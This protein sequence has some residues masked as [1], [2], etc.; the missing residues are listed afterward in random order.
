MTATRFTPW[1]WAAAALLAVELAAAGLALAPAPSAAYR[2]Q[3]LDKTDCWHSGQ[4]GVYRLGDTVR[5]RFETPEAGPEGVFACGW[6]TLEEGAWSLGQAAHLFFRLPADRPAGPLQLRLR[7]RVL[8]AP[9]QPE[10]R[11]ETFANGIP[12]PALRLDNGTVEVIAIDIPAAIA[13]ADTLDIRL[14]F[15]DAASPRSLGLGSHRGALALYLEAVTLST[16]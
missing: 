15:P 5:P 13:T 7:A 12:L 4:G 3:F 16:R 2:A 1:H 11:I 14:H 6:M 8:V 9:R 10:Q